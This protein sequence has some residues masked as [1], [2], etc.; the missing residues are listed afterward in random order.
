MVALPSATASLGRWSYKPQRAG[1]LG[2]CC[3]PG[4]EAPGRRGLLSKRSGAKPGCRGAGRPHLPLLNHDPTFLDGPQPLIG[5]PKSA[6][7]PEAEGVK[8]HAAGICKK[9]AGGLNCKTHTYNIK[10]HFS[11]AYVT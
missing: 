11:D 10:T 3:S 5:P 2:W 7:T 1:F 4:A 9:V 8:K 6:R